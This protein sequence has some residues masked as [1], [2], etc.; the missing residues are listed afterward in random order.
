MPDIL[1]LGLLNLIG[2]WQRPGNESVDI[3]AV[4]NRNMIN[5]QILYYSK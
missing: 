2:A 1:V 4:P 3:N 5:N